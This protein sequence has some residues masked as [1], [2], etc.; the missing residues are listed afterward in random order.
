MM[1]IVINCYIFNVFVDT[2]EKKEGHRKRCERDIWQICPISMLGV[3]VN[4]YL[5]EKPYPDAILLELNDID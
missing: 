4:I 5:V 2:W 1:F 3:L